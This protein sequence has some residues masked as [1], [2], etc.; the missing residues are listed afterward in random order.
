[1]KLTM[2]SRPLVITRRAKLLVLLAAVGAVAATGAVLGGEGAQPIAG[3]EVSAT[4]P[5]AKD[6]APALSGTDPITGKA[7]SLG[8]F[9]GK[10]VVINIWASWCP[11]CIKEARD[12][13]RFADAHPEAVVL[14]IDIQD[15]PA[16]AKG[17]YRRFGL[18]HPSIS[19]PS[20]ELSRKL[21]LFG[22]PTTI[23]LNGE[24][25]IVTRIVGETNLA[26]FE[27]GLEQA[28]TAR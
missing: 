3:P 13:R 2:R 28:K 22:L 27:R 7:V 10:P 5:A 19:D 16:G 17:F 9:A 26:G 18:T 21:G 15:T 11:G 12:L 25:R 1:M 23:F 6:P 14:G 8:D 24:H 4:E 20:G